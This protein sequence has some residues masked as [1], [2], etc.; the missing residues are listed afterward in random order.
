MGTPLLRGGAERMPV[1]GLASDRWAAV[2]A[3]AATFDDV[4]DYEGYELLDE[5]GADV[6]WSLLDLPEPVLW[7][8][9][10]ESRHSLI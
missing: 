10:N 2:A 6:D 1:L 3:S 8:L 9:A 5:E 4:R 7:R